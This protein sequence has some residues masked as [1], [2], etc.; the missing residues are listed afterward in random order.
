[1]TDFRGSTPSE[2][3]PQSFG[4]SSHRSNGS[5][6]VP[7]IVKAVWAK[8]VNKDGEWLTLEQHM[9]D[10][11]EVG[12]W[13]V[14]NW[15]PPGA[16][17]S[18]GNGVWP[19]EVAKK[20]A[21]F[22]CA[23]HDCGKASPA[24]A[25]QAPGLYAAMN[26][27]GLT[28]RASASGPRCHHTR[29]GYHLIERFL[30]GKGLTA[31]A[32]R[33]WAVVVA[34]HHG[35]VPA[36]SELNLAAPGRAPDFY[37]WD[38]PEAAA[39]WQ[40]VTGE[41][42]EQ[43]WAQAGL[44]TTDFGSD[45]V[46]SLA[47]QV[48]IG[49]LVIMAD[50]I[51]SNTALFPLG[52][53]TEQR[54]TEGLHTL[55]LPPPWRPGALS[56]DARQIFGSRF[57]LFITATPR[58]FQIEAVEAARWFSEPGLLLLEAAPGEG[59]TEAAL[60]AAEVL[61]QK[62][63]LG[64]VF[65]ALPTQAT[66]DAMF[67]R[68][69][70]WL[71]HLGEDDLPIGSTAWLGHSRRRLNRDYAGLPTVRLSDIHDEDGCGQ[72][73]VAAHEWLT[74]KK[75]LLATTVV[76]TIDQLLLAALPLKHGALRFLGL[77]GKVVVVDEVHAYDPFM[78]MHLVQ[79]LRWLGE[80]RV[81][82]VLLSATLP[83]GVRSELVAAYS[84]EASGRDAT[85]TAY[86]RITGTHR[87]VVRTWTPQASGR[88][89]RVALERL[90]D[91][92]P[93]IADRLES[94]LQEGGCALVVR[95]TVRSARDTAAYL[96]DRLGWP[97]ECHHAGFIAADRSSRDEG[98]LVRFGSPEYVVGRSGTRP[99][100]AVI[101]ATQV[102]EM[103]LDVDFDVLVTDLAPMDAVVQRMGRCHRHARARPAR[104][105][106]PRC[107]I[108]TDLD[109]ET[110]PQLPR[111]SVAVYG[112]ALLLATAA[113]LWPHFDDAIT[114]PDDIVELVEGTYAQQPDLPDSWRAA[115]TAAVEQEG[116]IER[117]RRAAAAAGEIA[118]PDDLVDL[119]GVAS[120]IG[121]RD[122]GGVAEGD[123]THPLVQAAV[124]DGL[125]SVEVL[126]LETTPEGQVCVPARVTGQAR[127]LDPTRRLTRAEADAM[128]GCVI[129]VTP[130]RWRPV[131]VLRQSLIAA[132]PSVWRDE[133]LIGRCPVLAVDRSGIAE[134]NETR[135]SY[136][137]DQGLEV[138]W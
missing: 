135:W 138:L 71:G 77:A 94:L 45:A 117:D 32:A 19:L 93:A 82:V 89:A 83:S 38:G 25:A 75:A 92:L 76:G 122:R 35:A 114:L 106:Q 90:N 6:D 91:D 50:W 81:P 54:S 84:G 110:T 118:A 41:L 44:E 20:V 131:Y 121:W 36:R 33:T 53:P 59:K 7:A 13:L 34:G 102:A 58:P 5:A 97:V 100:R 61:A 113:S 47:G 95:N 103:S 48:V 126:L 10:S 43:C 127:V 72:H 109:S 137:P 78:R 63:G 99:D 15:L 123:E 56:P 69:L 134:L 46:L 42:L 2:A 107:I 104:L 112:A 49:G 4:G 67:G 73:R 1:M 125:E 8:S 79:V 105:A 88:G 124:R 16:L 21:V 3:S 86:P 74:H 115:H 52:A 62:F 23:A 40:H 55:A 18:V 31:P 37:G 24:F 120:L 17:T 116:A 136:D 132:T 11:G 27:L 28:G 128:A 129:R 30:R 57:D 70:T 29:T 12:R 65:V 60:V 101:V 22:L 51:A 119:A 68:V 14:D 111:G 64:G 80:L 66:T 130:P 85:T 9:R 26:G 108:L 133:Q 96:R 98:L 39:Q 87:G